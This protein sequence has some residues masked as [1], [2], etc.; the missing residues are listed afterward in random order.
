MKSFL[1]STS[2]ITFLQKRVQAA[3]AVTVTLSREAL[4]TGIF[5]VYTGNNEQASLVRRVCVRRVVNLK[6]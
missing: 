5:E 3:V 1:D 4:I 2:S 6:N